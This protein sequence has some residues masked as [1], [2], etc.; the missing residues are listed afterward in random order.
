MNAALKITPGRDPELLPYQLPAEKAGIEWR[1]LDLALKAGESQKI[2]LYGLVGAPI[3]NPENDYDFTLPTVAGTEY[4]D[5]IEVVLKGGYQGSPN[6]IGVGDMAEQMYSLVARK[7]K[8]YGFRRRST[9]HLLLYATH[10]KFQPSDSVI[11]LLS[12]FC[13]RRRHGF[14]SVVVMMPMMDEA[15]LLW[16]C[17][18]TETAM[19]HEEEMVLRNRVLEQLSPLAARPTADGLGIEWKVD[20]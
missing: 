4:L 17:L 20:L 7:A 6:S 5:L 1:I 2:S 9:V 13:R 18:P 12:L 8:K 15:A 3:Q 10:W 19:S 11:A 16:R 14:K